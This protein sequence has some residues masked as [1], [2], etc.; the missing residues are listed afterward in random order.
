MTKWIEATDTDGDK[1]LLNV[2]TGTRIWKTG[3]GVCSLTD[4]D[5]EHEVIEFKANY[6]N[7]R[8]AI[9]PAAIS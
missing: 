4:L 3:E 9:K 7:V 5:P 6:D 8:D 1:T 2:E